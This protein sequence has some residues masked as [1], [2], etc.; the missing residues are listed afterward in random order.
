[1]S[2]LRIEQPLLLALME[3]MQRL[4]AL[5]PRPRLHPIRFH[6][7]LAPNAKL[8]KA[9]VPLPP[10]PPLVATAPAHADDCDHT[11]AGNGN[12]RMR[13]GAIVEAGVQYRNRALPVMRWSTAAHCGH[14]RADRHRSHP[15]GSGV[16]CAATTA[17][18]GRAGISVE[19]D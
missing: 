4:A 11:P 7:V 3:F 2:N 17:R 19:A 5:V 16:R 12:G 1:M 10:Q 8:R 9:V 6:G 18:G 13:W 14:R 15:H